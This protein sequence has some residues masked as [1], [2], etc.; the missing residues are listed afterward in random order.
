M[1]RKKFKTSVSS[2][3]V[4]LI[5]LKNG[6]KRKLA[7]PV[8][9]TPRVINFARAP[10]RTAD[11]SRVCL[12]LKRIWLSAGKAIRTR[13]D[14]K[15]CLFHC[16]TGWESDDWLDRGCSTVL[17]RHV[18]FQVPWHLAVRPNPIDGDSPKEWD[19]TARSLPLDSES[20]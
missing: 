4:T 6:L 11:L 8:V 16:V 20:R 2:L 5:C 13:H 1:R 15:G 9:G 12:G 3:N 17:P 14:I 7:T 19:S 10:D 18:P